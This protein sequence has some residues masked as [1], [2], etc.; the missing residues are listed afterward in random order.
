MILIAQRFLGKA[1]FIFYCGIVIVLINI[2]VLKVMKLSLLPEPV[3]MGTILMMSTFLATDM[4]AEF[5]GRKTAN[6][7]VFAGF[8][9]MLFTSTLMTLTIGINPHITDPQNGLLI[10]DFLWA[11][12]AISALF[13]PAPSLLIASIGAYLTSQFFDVAFFIHLKKIWHGKMLWLRALLATALSSL[14][15]TIVF[16]LLAWRVFAVVE[17]DTKTLIDTYMLGTYGIRLLLAGLN[18]AL[19]PVLMKFLNKDDTAGIACNN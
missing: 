9:G 15:D 13:L 14:I 8:L 16:S 5:Y 12:D 3:A 18:A 19:L 1:G 2:Q 4:A 11:H 6:Q 17:I 10:K 7:A